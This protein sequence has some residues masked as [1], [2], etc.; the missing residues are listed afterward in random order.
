MEGAMAYPIIKNN[1]SIEIKQEQEKFY[2]IIW[3]DETALSRSDVFNTA[4]GA[5]IAAYLLLNEQQKSGPDYFFEASNS[6]FM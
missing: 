2:A 4:A 1:L 6:A 5:S 3:Q